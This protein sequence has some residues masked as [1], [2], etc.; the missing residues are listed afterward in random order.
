L[1]THEISLSNQGFSNLVDKFKAEPNRQDICVSEESL[2]EYD[3]MRSYYILLKTNYYTSLT[4]P[5]Q[6]N[7]NLG[8]LSYAGDNE[9]LMT[10]KAEIDRIPSAK[11]KSNSILWIRNLNKNKLVLLKRKMKIC[12][13]NFKKYKIILRL[14]K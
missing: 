3:I 11:D 4:S 6:K 14:I 12:L 8:K 7:S 2:L 1:P 13:S 5:G 9:K 10:R